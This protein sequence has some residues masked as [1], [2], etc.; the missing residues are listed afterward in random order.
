MTETGANCGDELFTQR[1]HVRLSTEEIVEI[2]LCEGR[3]HEFVT[4]SWVDM[5]I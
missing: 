3:R 1:Y 2:M 4:P 5:L